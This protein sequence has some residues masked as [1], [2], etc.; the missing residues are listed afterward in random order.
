MKA[1]PIP[2]DQSSWGRFNELDERNRATLRD[3]LE[4][5]AKGGASQTPLDAK[6][7]DFYAACVDEA[8]VEAL[9]TTALK[10]ELDR[11]AALETPAGLPALLAGLHASG[12]G[13]LFDFGAEQDFKDTTQVI[14]QADQGGLG[15]PERDYYFKDDAKSVETRKQ[16]VDHVTKMFTLLGDAPPAAAAHAKT[17][18]GIETALAKASLTVTQRRDPQLL[19]HKMTLAELQKLSP[20]FDWN[21]YIV[22]TGAPRFE[23]LNVLVPDFVKAVEEQLKS[24]SLADWRT[25]LRWHAVH[26]AAPF[27]SSAFVNAHFDFYGKTLRGQKEIR[28]RWKRCVEYADDALGEALGQKFVE[29]TFGSEGKE[30]MN[31]MVTA[32]EQALEADIGELPWM[33]DATKKKALGKLA[34]IRRKI[35]YPDK[36]RDYGAYQVARGDFAGNMRRASAFESKRQLDKIGKPVD[37]GEWGMTPPTVNAYYNPLMNDINFPAGILQPPFFEGAMD[38][39]V[40]FGAIGAV[41][42]HEMTHG[43]DDAGRQFA[44]DGTLSDWWTEQDA[45]AFEERAQCFVDEYGAFTAVDDV[46]LNGKLTLGENTADNGGL[47]IAYRALMQTLA[48]G[49]RPP[50]DG[51]TPGQRFF[52]AWGQIWCSNRTDEAERLRA[53]TDPHSPGR[54]RVNGV[55]SNVPEFQ[56]AFACPASAPMVRQK[57][58][59]VW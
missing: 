33:T 25:Y 1:N 31:R 46:K 39:A 51:F 59:R 8:K 44:A 17:V 10:P 24:V 30:R 6:L 7:G 53:Q 58:C 34:A 5:A 50:R 38:D 26:A 16:Y 55:V 57:P 40:N 45:K 18:M 22:A 47:R 49:E 35:G 29:K 48:N 54:Y 21:A 56:Q 11:I 19:Y 23:S 3:L 13:A 15:L 42:G 37:R 14:A 36:W 43:F 4:A 32:L 41:I 28:A 27:L 52:L 9:G 12:V 20:S 2:P